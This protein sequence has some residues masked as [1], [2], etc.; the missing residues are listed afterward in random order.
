MCHARLGAAAQAGD[1]Y[2]RAVKWVQE[3]GRQLPAE[4]KEQLTAFGAEAEAVVEG[5]PA[6]KPM[7][8][9]K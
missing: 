4:W 8:K 9:G 1:C 3:H 5:K 6:E 2:D 7:S